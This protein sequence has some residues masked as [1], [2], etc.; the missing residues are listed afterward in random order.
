MC[1]KSRR[2]FGQLE[3]SD[4]NVL[5]IRLQLY[6]SSRTKQIINSL[7]RSTLHYIKSTGQ[8]GLLSGFCPRISPLFGPQFEPIPEPCMCIGL[9]SPYLTAWVSPCTIVVFL[10][11][12]KQKC[13]HCLQYKNCVWYKLSM[14]VLC[15]LYHHVSKKTKTLYTFESAAEYKNMWFSGKGFI[16]MDSLWTQLSND[17]NKSENYPWLGEHCSLLLWVWKLGC[18]GISLE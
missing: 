2:W 3:F 6:V 16:C 14:D 11:L 4:W 10:P 17:T 13:L 7:I 5:F 1:L 15:R 9:F 18:A 12:L 8:S